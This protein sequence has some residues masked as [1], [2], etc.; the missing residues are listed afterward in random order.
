MVTVPQSGQGLLKTPQNVLLDWHLSGSHG[1]WGI[2]NALVWCI[3]ID[4]IVYLSHA[5][6][7]PKHNLIHL[8]L[9]VKGRFDYLT[10]WHIF[11][12]IWFYSNVFSYLAHGSAKPLATEINGMCP[13]WSSC[14]RMKPGKVRGEKSRHRHCCIL[15]WIRVWSLVLQPGYTALHGVSALPVRMLAVYLQH[16]RLPFSPPLGIPTSGYK[17]RAK[18]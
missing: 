18:P 8:R 4:E 7:F 6:I 15:F 2:W 17:Q 1:S 10:A 5:I 12:W 13:T 14:S 16:M 9:C 11:G 3:G